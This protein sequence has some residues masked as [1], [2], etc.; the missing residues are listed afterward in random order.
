V[1]TRHPET[2]EVIH[3]FQKLFAQQRTANLPQ[4]S[5]L[6][7]YNHAYYL[8]VDCYIPPSEFGKWIAVGDEVVITG[9]Q[10]QLGL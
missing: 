5:T 4:W 8:S 9:K 1:P 2:G 10:Q 3:G 6:D 7:D